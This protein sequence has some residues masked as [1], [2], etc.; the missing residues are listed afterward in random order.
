MTEEEMP[1]LYYQFPA[2]SALPTKIELEM[3]S[4]EFSKRASLLAYEMQVGRGETNRFGM[5]Q[6]TVCYFSFSWLP[7]R[8]SA[9]CWSNLLFHL[10]YILFLPWIVPRCSLQE[11]SLQYWWHM[12]NRILQ[13]QNHIRQEVNAK[14]KGAGRIKPL[15]KVS[16]SPV[17]SERNDIATMLFSRKLYELRAQRWITK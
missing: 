4:S 14:N 3:Y 17:F 6:E 11:I 10:S 7:I 5:P 1:T 16:L 2:N 13:K 8:M 15:N 9:L 12:L